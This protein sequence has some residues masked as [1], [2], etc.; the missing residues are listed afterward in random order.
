M[1]VAIFGHSSALINF[2]KRREVSGTSALSELYVLNMAYTSNIGQT[3]FISKGG[4]AWMRLR[5]MNK[6]RMN[7]TDKYKYS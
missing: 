4:P 7:L 6:R 1:A 5:Y 2:N 3:Y